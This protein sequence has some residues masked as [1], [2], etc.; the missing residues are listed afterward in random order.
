MAS[1]QKI[2][3]QLEKKVDILLNDLEP[4]ELKKLIQKLTE[5]YY[6][7]Y[8]SNKPVVNEVTFNNLNK[9]VENYSSKFDVEAYINY[10]F[11][12]AVNGFLEKYVNE[13]IT[14]KP[15][16]VDLVKTESDVIVN[17]LE[18]VKQKRREL[19]ELID[20]KNVPEKF[21]KVQ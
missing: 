5:E 8:F 7:S 19:K 9:L 10:C 2:E 6:S 12:L 4:E 15:F 20:N 16:K 21:N 18:I 11:L 3:K 13:D 14:L 17:R 1:E